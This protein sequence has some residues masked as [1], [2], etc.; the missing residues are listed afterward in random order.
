[1]TCAL[2]PQI[3][4]FL[5]EVTAYTFCAII[6]IALSRFGTDPLSHFLRAYFI[7]LF[8]TIAGWLV[9]CMLFAL[10]FAPWPMKRRGRG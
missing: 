10:W 2:P 7:F 5:K 3:K 8:T 9:L 6:S 4:A 1:M